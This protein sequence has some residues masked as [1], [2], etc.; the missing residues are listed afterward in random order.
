MLQRNMQAAGCRG[1]VASLAGDN[2]PMPAPIPAIPGQ[3]VP[4]AVGAV[5]DLACRQ[6]DLD[7]RARDE[8][9]LLERLQY[10]PVSG[11]AL[12]AAAGVTRAAIWK[13]I[14]AL[15]A[16]G[17]EIQARPGQ[18][19]ALAHRLV[20]ID[21]AAIITAL[22]AA[23]RAE[24]DG[25]NALQVA[26]TVDST[27]TRLLRQPAPDRGCTLLLAERQSAGRGRRGRAWAS[28]L[29][30]HL[31]LSVARRFSGGLGRLGGLSLVAGIAAAEALAELGVPVRL[32]WPNDL[33]VDGGDGTPPRKLGGLLVEGGGEHAG[34]VRAVVGLGFNVRMPPAAATAIDQPWCD[35]AGV[36]DEVPDRNRLAAAVLGGML[37]ALRRF[38]KEGL[39]PFLP[40]YAAFDALAGRDV[41]VEDGGSRLVGTAMGLAAD[42]A[43]QV[44]VADGGARMFHAGEVRVRAR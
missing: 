37:P 28:P 17:V 6:H 21:A 2:V 3:A 1:R 14:Q 27:N 11:D 39:A 43:L 41:V 34:P 29:A 38:D 5:D 8:R 40:R 16:A 7:A 15:R 18:G 30:A 13:R 24:L 4:A 20:L 12:A 19:Y 9:A 44:R 32:K 33:V 31:Y 22:P 35:L 10:G 42:G 25:A 36:M 23:A 26:W